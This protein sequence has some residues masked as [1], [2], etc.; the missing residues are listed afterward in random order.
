[1]KQLM[2]GGAVLV[3]AALF[4]CNKSEPGGKI[5]NKTPSS[6]TFTIKAPTMP[7]KIKQG[8]KQTVKLTLDR[9][10]NFKQDVSLEAKTDKGVTVKLEPTT[11]KASGPETATATVSVDKNAP[12]GAHEVKVTAKPERGNA[13]D[14]TFKVNVEQRTD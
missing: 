6:E 8:D 10:R 12:V 4:G 14:V 5:D 11:V 7:T 9:G 1:M 2:I 13:T 3:A